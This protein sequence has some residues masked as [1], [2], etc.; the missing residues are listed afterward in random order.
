MK[1][2]YNKV[3]NEFHLYDDNSKISI[4]PEN[5]EEFINVAEETSPENHLRFFTGERIVYDFTMDDPYNNNRYTKQEMEESSYGIGS[6]VIDFKRHWKFIPVFPFVT[7][8][9]TTYYKLK[10]GWAKKK[11]TEPTSFYVSLH[12]TKL[13]DHRTED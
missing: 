12:E 4:L 11:E 6:F 3:T 9:T 2:V 1:V 5:E 8:V 7:T 10:D 13:F